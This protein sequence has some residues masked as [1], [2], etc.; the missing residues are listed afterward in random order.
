MSSNK[1]TKVTAPTTPAK[2]PEDAASQLKASLMEDAFAR[3][4][5][6]ADGEPQLAPGKPHAILAL[7]THARSGW[8][9]AKELQRRMFEAAGNG[10]LEMKFAFYGADDE[11]LVRRCQ[12]TSRWIHDA[13]TM[14]GTI[15]RAGECQCGCYLH[16]RSV[17]AQAV[18]EGRKQPLR[19]VVIVVDAFHDD[20]ESLD[21]AAIAANELRRM[22]TRL[23]LLQRS[24]NAT[25]TRLLQFL[26][27]VS[28][29][30]HFRFDPRTEERQ[31]AEIFAAVSTYTA[32]GEEAVKAT[33]G[34]AATL[35]LEYFKQAPMP[36]LEAREHVRVKRNTSP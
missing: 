33:S 16:I 29:C 10:G 13:D 2:Q 7:A 18:E 20:Q 19:A 14:S 35:L 34:E 31:F 6:K 27:N 3:M 28:G 12:I 8:D 36:V 26:A 30:A 15:D 22:G 9:R 21:R 1:V 24:T 32:G 4:F 23:F 5:G 17:L 11:H 25:T